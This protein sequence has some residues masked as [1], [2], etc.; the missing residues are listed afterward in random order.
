VANPP[1]SG[2]LAFMFAKRGLLY[3]TAGT[4]H[5]HVL[6]F[7]LLLPNVELRSG[8][9]TRQKIPFKAGCTYIDPMLYVMLTACFLALALLL[10][11]ACVSS[12]SYMV[13]F[14]RML[15][16]Q[17]GCTAADYAIMAENDSLIEMLVSLFSYCCRRH[18][19]LYFLSEGTVCT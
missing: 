19:E 11:C 9:F 18:L 8:V 13:I 7:P 10:V 3:V 5:M 6:A 17:S 2:R 4:K 12:P 15:S 14:L 1:V 16:P